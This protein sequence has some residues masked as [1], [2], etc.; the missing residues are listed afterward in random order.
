MK[1]IPEY[2]A[3]VIDKG[4]SDYNITTRKKKIRSCLGFGVLL[5]FLLCFFL[6]PRNPVIHLKKIYF[7]GNGN[8]YGNFK[9]TN[10]NFYKEKWSNPDISLYWVPYD[11]QVVGEK[12]YSINNPCNKYINN[13]CAIKLGEFKNTE[14]YNTKMQSSKHKQI[15]LLAVTNDEIACTSWMILNPYENLKQRLATTGT[16]NVKNMI[17]NKKK[18]VHTQYYYYG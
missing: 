10:K 14:H 3:L 6:I 17:N 5:T 11:G 18:G 16:I 1:A 13:K 2:H 7:D 12:C 15:D 9:L 8:G 4:D